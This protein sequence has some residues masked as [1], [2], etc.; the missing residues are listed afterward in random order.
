M[1]KIIL[2]AILLNVIFLTGFSGC[3]EKN[4]SSA[5]IIKNSPY[6]EFLYVNNNALKLFLNETSKKE[7]SDYFFM[8]FEGAYINTEKP[9]EIAL[10]TPLWVFGSLFQG[11]NIKSEQGFI[12]LNSNYVSK[13]VTNFSYPTQYN[14]IVYHGKNKTILFEINSDY[15]NFAVFMEDNIENRR[16]LKNISE[17]GGKKIKNKDIIEYNKVIQGTYF[18]DTKEFS[19]EFIFELIEN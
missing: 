7:L 10:K 17:I 6:P 12:F 4:Y 13:P 8:I 18:I 11:E 1:K 9:D 14:D 16:L 15:S 3:I 19:F 5:E 2:I